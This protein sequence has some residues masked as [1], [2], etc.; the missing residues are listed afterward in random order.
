MKF[1]LAILLLLL[2]SCMM[3]KQSEHGKA[4][5]QFTIK[6]EKALR[7]H[8][9]FQRMGSGGALMYDIEEVDLAYG[10]TIEHDIATARK[11]AVDCI[12]LFTTM[13][14]NDEKVQHYLHE[15]PFP[16]KRFE[17]TLFL[18]QP[19]GSYYEGDGVAVVLFCQNGLSYYRYEQRTDSPFCLH[20]MHEETYE[21]AKRIVEQQQGIVA[22]NKESIIRSYRLTAL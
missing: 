6:Y 4:L 12:T 10:V 20:S 15:R 2:T 9:C 5:Q 18:I 16:P 8:Y 13:I 11:V 1:L 21:E 14:N 22:K 19:D 17:L 3:H 7:Y